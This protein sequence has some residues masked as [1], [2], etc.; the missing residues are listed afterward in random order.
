[1]A[2]GTA[3][4]MMVAVVMLLATAGCQD[5][6][7]KIGQFTV[8]QPKTPLQATRV[9]LS[10]GPTQPKLTHAIYNTPTQ[11]EVNPGSDV[12]VINLTTGHATMTPAEGAAFPVPLSPD[13]LEVVREVVASRAWLFGVR[14]PAKKAESVAWYE[15]AVYDGDRLVE[16]EVAWAVPSAKPLP[17]SAQK[18]V[19]LF[20]T[21]HRLVNPLSRDVDL[22]K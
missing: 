16:R 5:G 1:M 6:G 20:A 12:L 9:V 19:T 3:A 17:D 8:I 10:R 2:R 11:A 14:A 15:L 13:R 7:L 22:L 18:L 4:W 21:A